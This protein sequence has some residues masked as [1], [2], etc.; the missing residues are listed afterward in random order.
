MQD[1]TFRDTLSWEEKARLNPLWA[2]MS[3][4]EFENLGPDPAA[5][6]AEQLELF[7]AKGRVLR[8][9]YLEPP[10]RRIGAVPER[11]R[12][13]EYGSGM[14]RLLN[15][16]AERGYACAGVDISATMLEHSRRLVPAVT[17]LHVVG[18]D[19][20][21]PLLDASA[22]YV[23]TYAVLQHIPRR[24]QVRRAVSEMCRVLRPGGLIRLQFQAASVPLQRPRNALVRAVNF[25]RRSLVYRWARL[26]RR[27]PVPE[28]VPLLPVIYLHRH[29]N[30]VGV[31]FRW[32]A[33]ESLLNRHGVCVYG[34]E[35]DVAAEWNSVWLLG[36]KSP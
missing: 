33:M 2:V 27:L 32:G 9:I 12:V 19:G 13:V 24:S 18:A 6:T 17:E 30:W 10:L 20:A 8:D 16:F 25:E 4:P 36:K 31:P 28:W 35:V 11:C 29:G 22:D 3:V 14:G 1:A 34:L 26:Q 23:Y 7:F 15:A 21:I 5:W